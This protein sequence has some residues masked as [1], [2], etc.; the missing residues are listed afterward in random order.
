MSSD[1]L[2]VWYFLYMKWF[3]ILFLGQIKREISTMKLVKHPNIVQLLEVGIC[4][5][6]SQS[7]MAAWPRRWFRSPSYISWF[8]RLVPS[9]SG[10]SPL[11]LNLLICYS[12]CKHRFHD[13]CLAG[14]CK[15]DKNLH[16]LRVRHR[17]W[18][19]WQNCKYILSPVIV[20]FLM[21]CFCMFSCYFH[22]ILL[23]FID[24]NL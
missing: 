10:V 20:L 23:L 17:W 19:L 7:G 16:C 2:L 8:M 6:L 22:R 9:I 13:C 12:F 14:A 21:F 3:F 4:L 18:A 1:V 15:Q 11:Y 24:N 5:N